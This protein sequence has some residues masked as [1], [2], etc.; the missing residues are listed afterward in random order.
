MFKPFKN[1]IALE[2]PLDYKK[3]AD[4]KAS[5]DPLNDAYISSKQYDELATKKI[6]TSG[7]FKDNRLDDRALNSIVRVI[8][9]HVQSED[10][11]T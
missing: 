10:L 7:L 4:S 9:R 2:L 1:V 5:K 3:D 6:N 11:F 8:N